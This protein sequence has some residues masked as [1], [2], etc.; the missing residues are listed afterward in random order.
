M[1]FISMHSAIMCVVLPWRTYEMH[2]DLSLKSG[3]DIHPVPSALLSSG[4]G[5]KPHLLHRFFNISRRFNQM[6][7][8]ANGSVRHVQ[9]AATKVR[10]IIIV[11]RYRWPN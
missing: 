4:H 2:S 6:T 7:R 11:R 5:F 8:C 1:T 3:C 9:V 10:T